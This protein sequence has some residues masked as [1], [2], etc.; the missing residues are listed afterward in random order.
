MAIQIF[1][2]GFH[3]FKFDLMS[4]FRHI[5]IFHAHQK[6]LTFQLCVLPLGLSSAPL[7][8]TKIFKAL[9]KSRGSKGMTIVIFLDDG[10]DDGLNF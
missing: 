3:L 9:L 5:E 8:F 6:F 4:G 2:K 10:L 7:V 1:D